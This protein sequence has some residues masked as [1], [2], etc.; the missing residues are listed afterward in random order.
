MFHD[1]G[2]CTSSH[3]LLCVGIMDASDNEPFLQPVGDIDCAV[4]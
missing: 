4:F 3:M 1:F 2:L